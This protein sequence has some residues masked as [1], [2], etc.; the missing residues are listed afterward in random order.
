MKKM[1]DVKKYLIGYKRVIIAV[2]CAAAALMLPVAA[3]SHT[4]GCKKDVVIVLDPGHGGVD[5]GAVSSDSALCEAD[6]NLAIALACRDE[7]ERYEGVKVYMTHTGVARG[8]KLS[9]DSRVNYVDEVGGD[10]LI[11][12]HC[13]DSDDLSEKGSE[14]YVSH[15]TYSDKYYHDCA[16]LAGGMLRR[17]SDLG[18]SVRGVKTRLSNGDRVYYHK[19]GSVEIGDYY[20]VIGGTIM[21]YG[22][23][24]ILVEH[25][26]VTGDEAFLADP[27]NLRA[28]GVA[29]ARAIAEHYGLAL[30][31]A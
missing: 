30:A 25:G 20:A 22:I 29:D 27:D 24:G 21:N 23:P 2:F 16:Q 26:F 5:S 9:L 3:I 17:F 19:D 6:L 14:V 15:S 10:I 28:L 4:A 13:N 11:S 1:R 18:L 8:D 31:A 12:L 7:L